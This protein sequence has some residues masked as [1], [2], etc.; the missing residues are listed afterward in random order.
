MLLTMPNERSSNHGITIGACIWCRSEYVIGCSRAY[1]Q[2]IF[3]SKKCEIEARFWL[4]ELLRGV[5]SLRLHNFE[6][7]SKGSGI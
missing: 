2:N 5:E 1:A 6:D 4:I 3:C 7:R